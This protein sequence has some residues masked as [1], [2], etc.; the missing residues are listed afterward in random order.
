MS[1]VASRYAEAFYSLSLEKDVLE[2][3]KKELK[4]INDIFSNVDN[5]KMFFLSEQI[6]KKNKKELIT[7]FLK[8]NVSK[9]TLNLF[10][11]LV[12]KGRISVYE[13]VI[14]EY[15]HLANDKLNIK[16][17]TIESVRPLDKKQVSE[18]ER[19]LSN[20]GK[21]VE[22]T[23]KINK[24]LISGFKVKF[25]DHIIDASMKERI[26][27]LHEMISRKGGQSWS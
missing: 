1:L 8:D 26:N 6:S 14:K 2:K 10:L 20:N 19:A 11:L 25:D 13:E 9:D 21:K 15:I 12:D 24:S 5:L 16:E 18:L 23:Q 7:K 27:D 17:G 3:N 22:L 4:K